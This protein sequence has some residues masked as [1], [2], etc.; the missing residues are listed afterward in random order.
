VRY[1]DISGDT[2]W[3]F[4]VGAYQD[5]ELNFTKTLKLRESL[6]YL[7]AP[8]NTDDYTVRLAIDLNQKISTIWS[9][10]LRYDYTYDAVVGTA[11]NRTQQRWA[12]LLGLDF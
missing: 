10:G 9:L 1:R 7:V 4:V 6:Y 12:L 5:L 3:Q 2:S 8:D 11:A